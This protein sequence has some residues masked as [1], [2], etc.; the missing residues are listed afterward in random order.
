MASRARARI[1]LRAAELV[2]TTQAIATTGCRR[3]EYESEHPYHESDP[4]P[5]PCRL[6]R[7]PLKIK[8]YW[9][10][11]DGKRGVLLEPPFDPARLAPEFETRRALGGLFVALETPVLRFVTRPEPDCP[12]EQRE[13]LL[14]ADGPFDVDVN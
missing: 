11:L 1:L 8:G 14:P 4:A 2:L 7:A 6:E 10:T 9:L 12:P 5:R 3:A 13:L